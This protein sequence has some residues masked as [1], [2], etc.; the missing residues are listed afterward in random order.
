MVVT[1]EGTDLLAKTIEEIHSD[2]V[3][4][5]VS[6][7]H[8]K[9]KYLPTG[10]EPGTREEGGL[11]VLAY[12]ILSMKE[13]KTYAASLGA[14]VLYD[15]A[16]KHYFWDGNK[17]TAYVMAKTLMSINGLELRPNYEDALEF[18]V[19]VAAKKI[20]KSALLEWIKENSVVVF[21]VEGDK[22]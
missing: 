8:E 21:T 20:N 18:I 14:E 4:T 5:T 1:K 6:E 9:Y 11:H 7:V 16:T 15:M 17:R 22:Q 19:N 3:S 10:G 2:I 13:K 12:K